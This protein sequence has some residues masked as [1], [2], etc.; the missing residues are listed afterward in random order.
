MGW[1]VLD[2]LGW[3]ETWNKCAGGLDRWWCGLGLGD[4]TPFSWSQIVLSL[5]TSIT[6][7]TLSSP[8]SCS[9]PIA[10]ERILS[11]IAIIFFDGLIEN[12]VLATFADSLRT[13]L[14]EKATTDAGFYVLKLLNEVLQCRRPLPP[15]FEMFFAVDFTKRNQNI[16]DGLSFYPHL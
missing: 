15:I 9:E 2:P 11:N 14:R 10:D 12:A 1:E 13:A 6:T 3:D 8:T 5:I 4:I 16:I 7:S